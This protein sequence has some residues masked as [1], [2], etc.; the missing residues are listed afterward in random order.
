VGALGVSISAIRSA[1]RPIWS[2]IL[3]PCHGHPPAVLVPP[4]VFFDELTIAI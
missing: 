3:V 1:L 2:P 4:I